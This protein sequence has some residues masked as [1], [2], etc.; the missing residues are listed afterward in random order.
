[1][2]FKVYYIPDGYD[3]R[4]VEELASFDSKSELVDYYKRSAD[5]LVFAKE[6]VGTEDIMDFEE[7]YLK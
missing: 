2:I 1:M 4:V 5:C 3:H 6:Y 7:R